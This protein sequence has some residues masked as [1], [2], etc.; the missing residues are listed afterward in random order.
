LRKAAISFVMSVGPHVTTQVLL[1][2]F[3]WYFILGIVLKYVFLGQI[4]VWLKLHKN[5]RHFTRKT[6]YVYDNISLNFYFGMGKVSDK[7]YRKLKYTFYFKYCFLWVSSRLGHNCRKF[8]RAR[9][10]KETIVCTYR[11]V[12]VW[13]NNAV[14]HSIRVVTSRPYAVTILSLHAIWMVHN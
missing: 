9:E 3:L 13:S 4:Q 5:I 7:S 14:W 11:F 12:V 8:S 10:A 1:G 2:G 6:E